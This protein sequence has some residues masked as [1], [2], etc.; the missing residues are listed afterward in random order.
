MK[1]KMNNLLRKAY[2]E[3]TEKFKPY[4]VMIDEIDRIRF[5]GTCDR[6]YNV[7][8]WDKIHGNIIASACSES[9][10]EEAI[11]KAF[12]KFKERGYAPRNTELTKETTQAN[13]QA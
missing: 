1:V 8:I 12:E 6:D 9:T 5:D 11:N 3:A 2:K 4:P 10:I 7:F 13:T